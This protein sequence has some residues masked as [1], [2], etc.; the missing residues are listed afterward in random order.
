MANNNVLTKFR[1]KLRTDELIRC[2]DKLDFAKGLQFLADVR[3]YALE[4]Q[5]NSKIN[6]RN[7]RKEKLH[8]E[9]N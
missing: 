8:L 4:K 9:Y 5:L 6:V 2:D 3:F 7:A 1:L